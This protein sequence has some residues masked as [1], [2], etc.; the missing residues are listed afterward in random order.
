M[1]EKR[2]RMTLDFEVTAE[3]LTEEW[4]REYY[5]QFE[6]SGKALVD[7]ETWENLCR[8]RRLQSA[9]LEDE[10]VLRRY[11]TYVTAVA[12]DASETSQ[13]AEVFGV[14]GKHPEEDILG[15]LIARLEPEDAEYFRKGIET[16][17]LFEIMQAVSDSLE[18]RWKGAV[19]EEV[20]VIGVGTPEAEESDKHLM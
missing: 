20:K 6:G 19:L 18:V 15:P 16:R 13:L 10:G 5:G 8:Q 4:L 2:L 12:V 9:L 14:G 7:E 1:L 11:L 17:S 3:E